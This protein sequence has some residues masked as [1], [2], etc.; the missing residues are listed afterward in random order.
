MHARILIVDDSTTMRAMVREA[1]ESGG[2]QVLEAVDGRAALH[3]L[4]G[5]SADLLVTDV[6]MPEMTAATGSRR[7]SSSRRRAARR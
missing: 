5:A 2:H 7:S 1:L 6:N 4:Q 3:A